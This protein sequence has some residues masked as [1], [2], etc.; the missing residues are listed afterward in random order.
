MLGSLNSPMRVA[1]PIFPTL[2]LVG[3][4]RVRIVEQTL[5]VLERELTVLVWCNVCQ[6]LRLRWF[7]T[8]NG[9][10]LEGALV[11][12]SGGFIFVVVR[13]HDAPRRRSD[14]CANERL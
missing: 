4:L 6:G 3:V 14:Y 8:V 2:P 7:L 5:A 10:E 13:V 11:N 1:E 9:V 12:C